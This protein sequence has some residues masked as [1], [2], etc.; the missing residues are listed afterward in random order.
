LRLVEE[1]DAEFIVD[2]RTDSSK[3][4]F[5]SFT[6]SNIEEQKKWIREY[7]NREKAEEEFYYIAIDENDEKFATYRL[8][9][10]NNNS[11]EVGSFVSKPFYKIA[12]NVIKVDVIL[13]TYVFEVLGYNSLN[14]EVRKNNK[15]VIIYHNKF[16]P[17]LTKEDDLNYYFKLEKDS[18]FANKNKF[19]K[20]F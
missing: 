16:K 14:F 17:Q 15:S 5:I 18:F 2:I 20:L 6:N 19:E 4:K 3:S 10:K 13:K 8:Y 1:S 12:L 11:I 9:N 7:K